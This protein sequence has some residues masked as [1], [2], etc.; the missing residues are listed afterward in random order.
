MKADDAFQVSG[1]GPFAAGR[2]PRSECT[3]IASK[4][5][6]PAPIEDTLEPYRWLLVHGYDPKPI[7]LSGE[8]AR[9]GR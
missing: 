6:F 3:V 1:S 4:H 2:L 8:S 7:L 9:S 5:P